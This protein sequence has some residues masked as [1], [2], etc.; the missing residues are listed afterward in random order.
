MLENAKQLVQWSLPVL[1]EATMFE[2][3]TLILCGHS[4]EKDE[5]R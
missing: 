2:E 5:G 1:E 4:D 3:A